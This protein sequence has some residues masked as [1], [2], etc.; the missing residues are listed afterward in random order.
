MDEDE[1]THHEDAE[2]KPVAGYHVDGDLR[3]DRGIV[4]EVDAEEVDV[5]AGAVEPPDERT[6]KAQQR[7]VH[8]EGPHRL[9]PNF[10]R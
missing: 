7:E 10:C 6:H 9:A 8:L 2:N 5:E 3:H 1:G 4:V